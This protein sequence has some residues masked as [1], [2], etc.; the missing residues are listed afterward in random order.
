MLKR[1]V[2]CVAAFALGVLL[3]HAQNRIPEG[4]RAYSPT[5]LQWLALEMEA[6]VAKDY[7]LEDGY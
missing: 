2:L 6:Q 4:A 3:T 5:R 7:R 1:I